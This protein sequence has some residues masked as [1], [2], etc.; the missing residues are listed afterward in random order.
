MGQAKNSIILALENWKTIKNRE[1]NNFGALVV[2][3]PPRKTPWRIMTISTPSGGKVQASIP[4][5]VK[6]GHQFT[7]QVPV[8]MIHGK[9]TGRK[10]APQSRHGKMVCCRNNGKGTILPGGNLIEK[11]SLRSERVR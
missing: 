9:N 11:L 2:R 8:W 6:A 1:K 3:V 10:G 7:V 4:E 5:G